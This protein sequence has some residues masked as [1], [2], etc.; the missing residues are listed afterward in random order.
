MNVT[1][2]GYFHAPC[3]L[4]MMICRPRGR[5]FSTLTV[6]FG[7]RHRTSSSP[8]RRL[9]HP[10]PQCLI[11]D[12]TTSTASSSKSDSIVCT[13]KLCYREDDRA[14]RPTYGY[15]EN[16]RDSL[17]TSTA[18]ILNIFMGFSSGRPYECSYKI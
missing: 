16:F 6:V 10:L 13:R 3:L 11:Y 18:T 1:T 4:V 8:R 15:P 9:P 14:M 12:E 17:T 5:F 7:R 2:P